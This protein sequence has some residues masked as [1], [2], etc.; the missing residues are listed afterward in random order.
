LVFANSSTLLIDNSEAMVNINDS[1][2]IEKIS[3]LEGNRWH[4]DQV[5]RARRDEI[6]V[7]YGDS[8]TARYIVLEDGE[9]VYSKTHGSQSNKA[10]QLGFRIVL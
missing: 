5:E 6:Q 10:E 8:A 3:Q 7:I 1:D 2:L 9:V 4:M